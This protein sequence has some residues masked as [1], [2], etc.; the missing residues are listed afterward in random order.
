MIL[1]TPKLAEGYIHQDQ[2]HPMG[3]YSSGEDSQ[4][5]AFSTQSPQSS[6]GDY[7][8]ETFCR[9]HAL[10]MVQKVKADQYM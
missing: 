9:Q 10:F 1:F 3:S 8:R 4:Q 5:A 6:F 7:W 2:C